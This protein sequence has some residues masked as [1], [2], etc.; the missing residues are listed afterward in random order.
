MFREDKKNMAHTRTF[1][2]AVTNITDL[3]KAVATFTVRVSEKLRFQR[4]AANIIGVFIETGRFK[5]KKYKYQ[6]SK[7]LNLPV[8]SDNTFELIK[9][10]PK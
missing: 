1:K 9:Y 6:N 5:N 7:I 10:E 4:S 8:P 2:T 3:K